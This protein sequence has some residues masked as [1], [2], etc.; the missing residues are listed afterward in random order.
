MYSTMVAVPV[1]GCCA[2][3]VQ[4]LLNGQFLAGSTGDVSNKLRMLVEP[5]L[6]Q[7]LKSKVLTFTQSVYTYV[8]VA[9]VMGLLVWLNG[10]WTSSCNCAQCL[11][12]IAGFFRSWMSG[13]VCLNVSILPLR[14]PHMVQLTLS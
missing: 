4:Y 2:G 10:F 14:L 12:L 9:G 3:V 11:S 6:N 1:C 8:Y 5:Y 13:I 7:L